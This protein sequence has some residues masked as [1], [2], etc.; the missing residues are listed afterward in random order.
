MCFSCKENKSTYLK[1]TTIC[2]I[3]GTPSTSD[4]LNLIPDSLKAKYN[5]ISFNRPGFGGTEISQTTNETI[6]ELAEKAGLQENDFGV[7]G[8]SGGA[9]IAMLLASKFKLK[10]CGIISGMVSKEAYFKFADSTITKD[11]FTNVLAGYDEFKKAVLKFPNLDEISKQA[12]TASKELFIKATYNEFEYLL[13][14]APYTSINKA[15]A[16]DWW[17]GENDV[18]VPY[19]SAELFLKDFKNAILNKIPNSSH[20]INSVIYIEKLIDGWEFK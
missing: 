18:N 8:I 12:G 7:I 9:P 6:F 19:K 5:F 17:H 4:I 15:I 1:K 3:G 10:H 11:L 14:E 16:V 13:S 2:V 20:D